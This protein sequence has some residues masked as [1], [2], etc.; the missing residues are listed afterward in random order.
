MHGNRELRIR[1]KNP[2][3]TYSHF[4]VWVQ[5]VARAD[6][7]KAQVMDVTSLLIS[8]AQH[9]AADMREH[10]SQLMYS[11]QLRKS[12]AKS[13]SELEKNEKRDFKTVVEAGFS[14]LARIVTLP[15]PYLARCSLS[16]RLSPF[17]SIAGTAYVNKAKGFAQEWQCEEMLAAE[18]ADYDSV[19]EG[20]DQV[21]DEDEVFGSRD[22][23]RSGVDTQG[24]S[25]AN[26]KIKV[27][28]RLARKRDK[29][30]KT[31]AD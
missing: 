16:S 15:M 3:N 21:H 25:V 9:C 27:K 10:D 29:E 17:S 4:T 31:P 23:S 2:T 19:D 13:L 22:A 20:K 18:A 8:Q 5:E 24:N 6:H 28:S 1:W 12:T 14:L 26:P 30:G 7:L 11:D